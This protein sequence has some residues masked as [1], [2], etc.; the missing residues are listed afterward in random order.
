[1]WTILLFIFIAYLL[2][3]KNQE[4][5]K[6]LKENFETKKK[7]VDYGIYKRSL[8]ATLKELGDNYKIVK[9]IDFSK[10]GPVIKMKIFIHDIESYTMRLY[11]SVVNL[12]LNIN[13]EYEAQVKI[14]EEKDNS[15]LTMGEL[16]DVYF[17]EL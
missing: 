2:F 13:N 14:I 12:P 8:K 4:Y 15:E 3:L 6:Q 16:T 10:T 11:E 1:M 9:V 17:S 5:P 7:N